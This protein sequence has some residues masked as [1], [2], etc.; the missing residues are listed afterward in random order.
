MVA[1]GLGDWPPL[2][3]VEPGSSVGLAVFLSLGGCVGECICLSYTVAYID[4][5]KLSNA[6]RCFDIVF[7]TPDSVTQ[8]FHR[9]RGILGRLEYEA[10]LVAPDPV[11]VD[12]E[13]VGGGNVVLEYL[14]PGGVADLVVDELELVVVRPDNDGVL[15]PLGIKLPCL[16]VLGASHRVSAAFVNESHESLGVL[17]I[18]NEPTD[19]GLGLL[20]W[21]LI[22]VFTG[23]GTTL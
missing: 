7:D 11:D 14:I 12:A 20:D 16:Q 8:P 6:F 23:R 1:S 18:G 3:L 10:E 2:E 21:H 13:L 19:F 4:T 5:T 9:A 22:E 17:W 15:V